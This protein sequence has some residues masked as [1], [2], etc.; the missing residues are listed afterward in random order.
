ML[1]L[2]VYYP[3]WNLTL[4]FQSFS[5]TRCFSSLFVNSTRRPQLLTNPFILVS[6]SVSA[7]RNIF[8]LSFYA[9]V[10]LCIVLPLALIFLYLWY[11]AYLY[12]MHLH[13]T[14]VGW[15]AETTFEEAWQ[16]S[17]IIRIYF[18]RPGVL[19]PLGDPGLSR[20]NTNF[21]ADFNPGSEYYC[22]VSFFQ[23]PFVTNQI[24]CK[25]YS[26]L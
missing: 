12:L 17:D 11:R 2:S 10:A 5:T 13:L 4:P 16:I 21:K 24:C 8:S 20:R 7:C 14:Y 19:S 23:D 3:F 18:L 6:L 9:F 15:V 1:Q 26:I 25:P 22:Q